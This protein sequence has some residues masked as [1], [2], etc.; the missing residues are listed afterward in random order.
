VVLISD[1]AD[2]GAGLDVEMLGEIASF[3]VPV[4]TIG[5]GREVI[6]ED[7]E[8]MDVRVPAKVLP[9]SRLAAQVSIRHDAAGDARV[10]VYEDGNFLASQD[11]ALAEDTQVST[12]WIEL[13]AADPGQRILTFT[14]DRLQDEQN[15]DNNTR[16][17]VLEI[18][19]NTYRILYV[20]G[21]PRWE[22]KFMRRALTEDDGVELVT[23]LRVSPNK[24]YRQGIENEEEL[25]D[26]FPVDAAT[27]FEYDALII[28]SIEAAVFTPEQQVLIRDF[29]NLRGG[30]LMMLAGLNGLAQGGWDKSPVN[31]VL[32]AD[33]SSAVSGFVRERASVSLTPA[34]NLSPLLSFSEDE[35]ENARLWDELPDIADY[36][37]MGE[38]RPAAVSLLEA[39]TAGVS[40]PLLASQPYGRGQSYILATGGTWRWQMSL[41][42]EDQRHE[43]FWRQLA[44]GLVS[45]SPG[46]FQLSANSEANRISI[47]ADIRNDDFTPM[48]DVEV[49]A[50]VSPESG[51]PIN[52]VLQSVDGRPGILQGEF[53]TE[54][55]GLYFI[56]SMSRQGEESINTSRL[57]ISNDADNTEH[58]AYRQNRALLERLSDE[59][60][61]RYWTPDQLGGLPAAIGSSRSGIRE[62]QLHPLWDAPVV[63]LLLL[64]LK[65]ME[66]MLRRRWKTI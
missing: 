23:M 44:R 3:G 34:G 56:E 55:S 36:Q 17:R 32:P 61:G 43:T 25:H 51:E 41:P 9:G 62:Q 38:L 40:I 65:S 53:N 45:G 2:N 6:P 63:F 24:F 12:A 14:L 4:H 37:G 29:V 42:V 28:G 47:T 50:M 5:V 60:G 21:E 33:L 58:F 49:T 20:E 48:R 16:V 27:L 64:L 30:S 54:Q 39:S 7:L 66:W 18:P 19:A 11:V 57:T 13:T 22:Y 26:G 10:K 31:D 59:T 52:V 15:I 8:L 1:G 35:R 46:R